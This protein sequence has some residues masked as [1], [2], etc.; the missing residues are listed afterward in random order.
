MHDN[1]HEPSHYKLPIRAELNGSIVRV[2]IQCKDL[3]QALGF[4]ESWPLA[5]CIKYLFRL[6]KKD[7]T[8]ELE[9][10][11]KSREFLSME[12]DYRKERQVDHGCTWPHS[13]GG[14][15]SDKALADAEPIP[16][17]FQK[18]RCDI[19]VTSSWSGVNND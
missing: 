2:N 3:I 19:E 7:P 6:G 1:V 5:S 10:I 4:Y 14:R 18:T 13:W 15:P 8:K 17:N 11:E 16:H 9:D 12:I